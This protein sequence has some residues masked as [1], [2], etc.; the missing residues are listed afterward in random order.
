M[1]TAPYVYFTFTAN[2]QPHVTVFNATTT[3]VTTASTCVMHPHG[4]SDH[5]VLTVKEIASMHFRNFVS[6][7]HPA[8]GIEIDEIRQTVNPC[9]AYNPTLEANLDV[10]AHDT[11]SMH[12]TCPCSASLCHCCNWFEAPKPTRQHHGA[13][14]TS[15]ELV[16]AMNELTKHITTYI[17]HTASRIMQLR[18][19]RPP[20][21][22]GLPPS[23]FQPLSGRERQ[24]TK[25]RAPPNACKGRRGTGRPER[26]DSS[27]QMVCGLYLRTV[28]VC[29]PG[30]NEVREPGGPAG[31]SECAWPCARNLHSAPGQFAG[32]NDTDRS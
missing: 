21:S 15:K 18:R 19:G 6:H 26:S 31:S 28:D 20:A 17:R 30:Y 13:I 11:V 3:N 1:T 5:V 14:L 8:E 27:S 10:V 22:G 24:T 12:F 2:S 25:P 9:R 16:H 29:G 23:A 4:C 32:H 7:V